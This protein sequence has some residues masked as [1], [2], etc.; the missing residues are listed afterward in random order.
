MGI[1]WTGFDLKIILFSLFVAY[2]CGRVSRKLFS[3]LNS[4]EILLPSQSFATCFHHRPLLLNLVRWCF[5]TPP[6]L[7]GHNIPLQGWKSIVPFYSM[8]WGTSSS[9]DFGGNFLSSPSFIFSLFILIPLPPTLFCHFRLS[10]Y[11]YSRHYTQS[12]HYRVTYI[13]PALW[14][15]DLLLFVSLLADIHYSLSFPLCSQMHGFEV[16]P[17]PAFV[18]QSLWSS[19]SV[20]NS[21]YSLDWKLN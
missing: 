8:L 3:G 21:V 7:A 18:E 13:P 17:S 10:L 16:S 2:G 20:H 12:P 5:N 11:L 19:F 14:P 15:C 1:V 9:R 4:F 6:W